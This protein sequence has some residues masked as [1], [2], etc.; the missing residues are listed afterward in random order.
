MTMTRIQVEPDALESIAAV[1]IWCDACNWT[2]VIGDAEPGPEG[3]LLCPSC[4]AEIVV[5]TSGR[6]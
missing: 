1:P 3:E 5:T 4:M 6:P 2:G